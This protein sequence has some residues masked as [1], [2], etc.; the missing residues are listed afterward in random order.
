MYQ[1]DS[2]C[3]SSNTLESLRL[4]LLDL[5]ARNRLINYKHPKRSSLRIIDELPDQLVE[6]LLSEKEMRFLP[7][8]EPTS[9]KLVKAGYIE[10][11]KETGVERKLKAPPTAKEWAGW[12]GYNISY[13]A[14][15]PLSG[16]VEEKHSDR[17]I[18]T[19]LFPSE[20]ENCLKHLRQTAE[21]AIQEM[22]ANILYMAFGFLEW[23]END[24]SKSYLAPLFLVPMRLHK[25]RLD[26]K[27]GTYQYSVNYSGEEIISN[28][29]LREKLHADF[30]I[31]LPE[32]DEN[33]K[34]EAYFRAVQRLIEQNKPKWRIRRYITLGLLNFSKLLMYLDLDPDRWPEGAKITD[35]KIINRFLCGDYQ[36]DTEIDSDDLGFGEEYAI[37][38]IPDIHKKYPLIEDA[39]SSQH[40]ALIDA[41][42]GK[43]L[44]IEG[45]PGSGKSQTITNLIAAAMAQG[46][47]VLFVAEKM[48]ALEVV[49]RRL[50]AAGLGDFCLELHSHK[51]QKRRVLDDI[52]QR[53]QKYGQFRKP[54]EIDIDIARFEEL[55][56][57]LKE[58]VE[59]INS[60]WKDTGKSLHEIFMAAT[61][62]RE[63]VGLNPANFHPEVP[64]DVAL[65]SLTIKRLEDEADTL[66][67]VSQTIALQNDG[68]K[69]LQH[70]PWYGV[71]N[72]TLQIF[73]FER[74][75]SSLQL[76]QDEL[77]KLDDF[78]LM[79]I[80]QFGGNDD[81]LLNTLQDMSSFQKE[82]ASIPQL[83]G[84][85]ILASLPRLTGGQL[86]DA[87]RAVEQFVT[88]Q[89]LSESLFEKTGLEIFKDQQMI[90][91]IKAAFQHIVD[92]AQGM[93]EIGTLSEAI[94]VL[95]TTHDELGE[96][97]ELF[98]DIQDMVGEK[99]G[100]LLQLN[101]AGFEEL[102]QF[103]ELAVRLKLPLWKMRDE[104]FDN[105]ELDDILPE[106]HSEL[107]EVNSIKAELQDVFDIERLPSSDTL[108]Q[109]RAT[110]NA[111]GF[112][113]WLNGKCR[114]ARSH[115]KNMGKKGVGFAKLVA[116]L[117]KA[118][119]FIEL[120]YK[121]ENNERYRSM[122]GNHFKGEHT[123]IAAI[124]EVRE[125][126]SE[127]RDNYGFG[128]GAKVALGNTLLE[129]SYE[130][131]RSVLSLE[132]RGTLDQLNRLL[133]NLEI[134]R[135]V[136]D[137]VAE[138]QD[139][140]ALLVG[141]HSIISKLNHELLEAWEKCA[142][143]VSDNSV[144][145][146]ELI[147][148]VEKI[149]LLQEDIIA[150]EEDDC[151]DRLFHG[152]AKL[153]LGLNRD[154]T[155][156]L[157]MLGNTLGLATYIDS[158]LGNTLIR[159]HIYA[160][161]SEA[162][163]LTLA[164]QAKALQ[165]LLDSHKKAFTHFEELM[166]LESNRW[167][168]TCGDAVPALLTRNHKALNNIESLHAWLNYVRTCN[169]ARDIGLASMVSELEQGRIEADKILTACKAGI[170]DFLAR[171][172]L[173]ERPELEHFFGHQQEAIAVQFRKYDEK[174]KK[175]Q[176]EKI[177]WQIDQTKVPKGRSGARASDRTEL[178]LLKHEGGKKKR[179]VPIRQLILRA[180]EALVAL[181]PCFMMGPMSVAHYLAPGKIKFDLVV[182]D[183]AS[184]IKPQ[185]ALGAIA[186][187]TQL[188]VV[189]DPKQLPPTS[190]FDRVISDEEDDP[191]VLEES[192]SILDATLPMF[193]ARRL[194][195]HYRSQHESLIAFSNHAFYNNDLI[196]FPSP[197]KESYGYG[198]KFQRIAE[199]FFVNRRNMVE[200]EVI[201]AAVR[202]HF[203]ENSKETL[204]VVAMSAEQRLQIEVAIEKL[205][206]SDGAFRSMLEND[207]TKNEALFVKN[208]EN[209]QGDERDVIFI[210][211]TYGPPA[212]GA[213]VPQ[214]FGPINF[215]E[216][217]RRLNVLF[218]RSRKRMH[219]FSS[220]GSDD[221]VVGTSSKRGVTALRDFLAYC[222]TGILHTQERETGREPDSD[223][224]IAVMEALE[225]RGFE[226]VPQVGVAG[227][228]ID[229]AVVD[230]AN[231][232][233]YL[234][235][236]ECDG[237]SYHSAKSTR[238][239]DKL[240]QAI[241]ERLGWRIRRI[242]ST[243]WFNNPHAE[244]EPIVKELKSKI[245][246][247]EM[248]SHASSVNPNEACSAVGDIIMPPPDVL[249]P[250]VDIHNTANEI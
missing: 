88:I 105:E 176:C 224:E 38:E 162:T 80:E 212:P 178:K 78:R 232:G 125:W 65:D 9:R 194:R 52:E 111:C 112:F 163:F 10:I 113:W 106:L 159:E 240:R 210:S 204:G 146:D 77:E 48:A 217:W 7:V 92:N 231:P 161:P 218:T 138:L 49:R 68:I 122:L 24:N 85:E 2:Y 219:V 32:L 8:P 81:R 175:L 155:E 99:A 13:E 142:P 216:G 169:H 171:Q 209:V 139:D 245:D 237:A 149:D 244:L 102:I 173:K 34:P 33:T 36:E 62:Y 248:N 168:K 58:H 128:F 114:A 225:S 104:C 79:M 136:F 54:R 141:K 198:I 242:W 43:D 144:T 170:F 187:G 132:K 221:I 140:S 37:D 121:L 134:L 166:Q 233:R 184:Q 27:S 206:K 97:E 35:H 11:D 153:E 236:I 18:Q 195:W 14:P 41:V 157:E 93:V 226:C 91:E 243:D 96:V 181:K 108:S 66:L 120:R 239:R 127:V 202:E 165:A 133:D 220:M 83:K 73:D 50:D 174:L 19:L 119:T 177:A 70:H 238:D 1:P 63:E 190:F 185:D 98:D 196:L 95:K 30:G 241:L 167:M 156:A 39:D 234:M 189:G 201:A 191:A 179:H 107:E 109:I 247:T 188:V 86:E 89:E 64:E 249:E 154:N 28:L 222:E 76:W 117:E 25:G 29:S 172:I 205:A 186:R 60:P 51:S 21:S 46:K 150:W 235:G 57:K 211:M 203:M 126:Y 182:M 23:F 250:F 56:E 228:F 20:L 123:D 71:R 164:D 67:S 213:R 53:L 40:S 17:A 143:L 4:R 42:D 75:Q 61:R 118:E 69:N 129:L 87:K 45:P 208:L 31:A 6:T 110:I 16:S 145:L 215:D 44:V 183:E 227:F 197:H 90:K 72:D 55:K 230:P 22:G 223:F 103:I 15:T 200:A 12:L 84:D 135:E 94:G 151:L 74:V 137:P 246:S 47:R 124:E 115:L 152:S 147:E 130:E 3:Y 192:E 82:L 148:Q 158:G 5:S 214:R 160:N 100:K 193:Q 59:L 131:A 116:L 101:M 26:S 229:I 207:S 199:G 180:G